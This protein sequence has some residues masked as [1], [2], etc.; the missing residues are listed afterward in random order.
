[1]KVCIFGAGAVGGHIATRLINANVK[2][3]EISIVAR[4]AMLKAIRERGL[5]L[6]SNGK[7]EFHVKPKIVTDDPATLPP[8]DVVLVTVKAHALS[9]AAPA[10]GKM[11]KPD[12]VAVFLLNGIP[13]W[14]QH[15]YKGA[16][17]T[18]PLLDPEGALWR[19]VKPERTLGCV[20]FSPND[21]VEPGVIVHTGQ[22]YLTIGEPDNKT[23]PRLQAVVDMLNR[24]NVEARISNDLRREIWQKL[25]L[26]ASGNTV[27]AITHNDLAQVGADDGLVNI[28]VNIMKETLA[29]AAAQ[30]W[31]LRAETDC[32]TAAR[33]GRPG[34]RTSMMQDALAKR[35]MECEALLGQTQAFALGL[36]IATPTIDVVL[37]LLRGLDRSFRTK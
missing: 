2:D 5:T 27:S 3:D 25:C 30:G 4:G 18:L 26:N 16:T 12:G 1:M 31:D 8:Q 10:I 11:L 17:G 22:S 37:P 36:G 6:R 23:T 24:G 7:E 21:M 35:P 14:F 29:V 19:E 20:V 15:G 33:R 13:W 28:S 34:Q 9:A 32:E